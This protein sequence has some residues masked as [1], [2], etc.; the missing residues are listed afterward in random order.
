MGSKPASTRAGDEGFTLIELLVAMTVM[1]VVT[2]IA[3]AGI[4][5]MY[6]SADDVDTRSVAQAELGLALQ[7]LDRQV[8]YAEGVSTTPDTGA[9]T[10]DFLTIQG[11]Q[12]VCVQ[13]RVVAG[14]LSQRTWAYA[15]NP[16]N[17]TPWRPLASGLTSARPFTY[18]PPD[19]SLGHQRLRIDLRR[20]QDANQA[21]FTALNTD[22]T[23]G[24]DYCAAGRT[25]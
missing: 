12:Q 18:V 13:L 16:I 11:T 8:R 6:R 17:P 14:V 4:V 5:S 2:S 3:T 22:R 1:V 15:G 20:E 23:S 9:S 7:R 21:T 10:V 24:N 19:D 25:P